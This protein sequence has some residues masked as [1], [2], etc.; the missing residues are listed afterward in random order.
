MATS[1]EQFQV[2]KTIIIIMIICTAVY[3]YFYRI[4]CI[5][6]KITHHCRQHIRPLSL[7]L[8]HKDNA[9]HFLSRQY[10]S[11]F[12]RLTAYYY[13]C[14]NGLYV[15]VDGEKG[16]VK[17]IAMPFSAPS[18]IMHEHECVPNVVE[19]VNDCECCECQANR[20]VLIVKVS[21]HTSRVDVCEFIVW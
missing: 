14:H 7:S 5:S 10:F 16:K 3:F 11:G 9:H 12:L 20:L 15:M 21:S 4:V 17:T 2:I 8:P 1:T 6:G 13:Y 19:C 18:A